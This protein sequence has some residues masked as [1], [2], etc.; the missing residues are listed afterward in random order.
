MGQMNKKVLFCATVIGHIVTFHQPYLRFFK[1]RGFEVHVAAKNNGAHLDCIDKLY[2]VPFSRSPFKLNN[3]N[4]YRMIKK[5]IKEN[6]Y[7]IIHFH[8]PVASVLGR[9]AAR[10]AHKKGTNVLYT[11]H[12]FHFF[13]GA[14][15]IN[16]LIYYPVER[17]FA[18][19]TDGII[20]MNEED[21]K[22]A[23]GLRLR[24]DEAVYYVNG[25]G[26]DLNRFEPQT[27]RR[28][29]DKRKQYGYNDDD[30][31]LIYVAELSERKN[32]YL[33][34]QAM[35]I[36]KDKI[37]NGK[38]IL[39]GSG[40]LEELYKNMV[41]NLGL[42]RNV[43]F[44]GYRKDIPDLM[45]LS[46]VAVSTSRQ[47]GLPVNVMEAMATGLPLIVTNA[48]G[49][50]DLVRNGDNGYVVPL[51]NAESLAKAIELLYESEEQRQ[52]FGQR[53]LELIEKYSLSSVLKEMEAV[54]QRYLS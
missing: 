23:Q 46:D 45:A 21:Y 10:K 14:S 30:F 53:N 12:G 37:K 49:N 39:V 13:K 33:L 29:L 25:V 34:I 24:Q 43:D 1:E 18:R 22:R 38:L 2:D 47:E 52:R 32:Q 26:I 31:I 48:R 6:N 20:T 44:L 7:Q 35:S 28:K 50:R 16:W 54:Y 19:W 8:T 9:L 4:A 17:F 36:V 5:I 41:T 51:N 3:V 40:P 42:Q 27:E 15:L 11:A